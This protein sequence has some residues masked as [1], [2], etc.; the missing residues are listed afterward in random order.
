MAVILYLH[1]KQK[2]NE[3]KGINS[4]SKKLQDNS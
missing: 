2:T 1:K 3:T 4:F